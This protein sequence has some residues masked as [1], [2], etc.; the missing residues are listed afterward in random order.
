MSVQIA[1]ADLLYGA[2]AVEAAVEARVAGARALARQWFGV[3]LRPAAP[4]DAWLLA[5]L[6]GYLEDLYV[7]RFMGRNELAYRRAPDVQSNPPDAMAMC[8]NPTPQHVCRRGYET[9]TVFLQSACA[10]VGMPVS[11]L[12]SCH[13]L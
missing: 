10:P 6:A 2:R 11:G 12:P 4:A 13:C 9:A 3:W 5:G 7:R 8:T 1:S